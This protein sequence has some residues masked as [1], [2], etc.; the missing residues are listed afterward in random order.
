MLP[1]RQRAAQKQNSTTILVLKPAEL[2]VHGWHV[3]VPS[4]EVGETRF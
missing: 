2:V 1:W 3:E 4:C